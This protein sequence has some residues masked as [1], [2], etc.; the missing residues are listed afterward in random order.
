MKKSVGASALQADALWLGNP[1][2]ELDI[3]LLSRAKRAKDYASRLTA[4]PKYFS[5]ARVEVA[6][7]GV[8]KKNIVFDMIEA[9]RTSWFS[10]TRVKSSSWTDLP[11]AANWELSDKGRY[12]SV[13]GTANR[14]FYVN[15]SVE[16]GCDGNAGW[17][18]YSTLTSNSCSYDGPATG[19][20]S[21]A[22]GTTKADGSAMVTAETL[23]VFGR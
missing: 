20:I 23:M 17:L 19:K 6:T 3:T 7:G 15:Y 18:L 8:V 11:T 10:P 14:D 4:M 22:P 1:L 5:E 2:N 9:T 16:N 13:A 12:F 21:Y